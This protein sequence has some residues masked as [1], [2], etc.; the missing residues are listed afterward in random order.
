MVEDYELV[1]VRPLYKRKAP[2][3][4][5]AGA[6]QHRREAEPVVLSSG[7]AHVFAA[8]TLRALTAIERDGLAFTELVEM[9]LRAGRIVEEVF[10]AVIREDEAESFVR[11][12]PLDGS[13]HSEFLR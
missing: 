4:K 3:T 13:V 6:S 9:R 12:E 8:G 2:A 1:V 11:D 10:V 7:D 5:V